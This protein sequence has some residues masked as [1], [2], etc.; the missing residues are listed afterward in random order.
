VHVPRPKKSGDKPPFVIVRFLTRFDADSVRAACKTRKLPPGVRIAD[1]LPPEH[2]K[3]RMELYTRL[4]TK[5]A[6]AK[7]ADANVKIYAK[8][9]H[10]RD[11]AALVIGETA[12]KLADLPGPSGGS[13]A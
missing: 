12:Y 3:L 4:K 5:V 7:A 10:S 9:L 11:T 1:M 8:M 6:D 2:H 13:A